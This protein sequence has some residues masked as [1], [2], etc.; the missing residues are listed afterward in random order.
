MVYVESDEYKSL[1]RLC[2]GN[3]G[4]GEL[5]KAVEEKWKE[6]KADQ[7]LYAHYRSLSDAQREKYY[8]D[9]DRY[10]AVAGAAAVTN[11]K[12]SRKSEGAKAPQRQRCRKLAMRAEP[13]N[14]DY[15][16]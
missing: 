10:E 4:I 14:V 15:L 5:A 2:S 7:A 12:R 13:L 1:C 16:P 9:K 6:V 3:E 11:K 8:Q